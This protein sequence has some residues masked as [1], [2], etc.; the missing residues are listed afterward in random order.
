ML[1]PIASSLQDR[2]LDVRVGWQSWQQGLTTGCDT[3]AW[4]QGVTA[5]QVALVAIEV[6]GY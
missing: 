3:R 1:A 6:D 5:G 4:Q 2:W